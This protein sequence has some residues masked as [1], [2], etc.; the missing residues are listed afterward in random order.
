MAFLLHT[1]PTA[2]MT[3]QQVTVVQATQAVAP[4]NTYRCVG[5]GAVLHFDAL[6]ASCQCLDE[7]YSEAPSASLQVAWQHPLRPRASS[8]K[9]RGTVRFAA[10]AA[11]RRSGG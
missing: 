7:C 5:C 2:D 4:V 10:V 8:T 1:A 6:S 11:S 3:V 9:V